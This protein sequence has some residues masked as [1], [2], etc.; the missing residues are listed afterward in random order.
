MRS[1][2]FNSINILSPSA[3]KLYIHL[4]R[5]CIIKEILLPDFFSLFP[6][7]F[8]SYTEKHIYPTEKSCAF[9]I[10]CTIIRPPNKFS[11]E[12]NSDMW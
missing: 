1:G 10:Y 3:D 9:L 8:I 12:K 7:I 11:L 2:I 6:C 5:Y 4:Y